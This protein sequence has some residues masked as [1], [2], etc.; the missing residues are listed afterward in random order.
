MGRAR[1]VFLASC[2]SMDIIRGEF[3]HPLAFVCLSEEV[4]RVRDARVTCEQVIV[5]EFQYFASLVEV[6]GEFGLGEAFGWQ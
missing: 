2:A 5:I 6:V 4:C 3:F 1:F